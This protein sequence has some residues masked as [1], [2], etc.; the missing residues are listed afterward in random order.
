[1]LKNFTSTIIGVVAI[2]SA[3]A[4][5]PAPAVGTDSPPPT[6]AAGNQASPTP[7]GS[8]NN[9]PFTGLD[10]WIDIASGPN[11]N[12]VPTFVTRP[13]GVEEQTVTGVLS[14][15]HIQKSADPERLDVAWLLIVPDEP[16]KQPVNIYALLPI[17]FNW[18]AVLCLPNDIVRNE[19]G[20]PYCHALNALLQRDL[21]LSVW[22]Y[23]TAPNAQV[24]ILDSVSLVSAPPK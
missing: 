6:P 7:G 10:L 15:Y 18:A 20:R 9:N 5:H 4:L 12:L 21:S 16:K 11:R 1:M 23:K 8:G 13:S 24:L 14:L 17:T 3:A 19:K 22:P 2:L